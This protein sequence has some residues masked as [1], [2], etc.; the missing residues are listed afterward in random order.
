MMYRITTVCLGNICRS[1]MAEAVI[2]ARVKDAGL[3]AAVLVDSAGTDGWHIGEDADPRALQTLRAAGYD[4][5]HSGR[6]I[7]TEWFLEPGR[8]DLL[9]TMDSSNYVT[10]ASLAP[11]EFARE[12]VRML[13]SFDPALADVAVG[14]PRLD[15]PD[16]WYGAHDGFIDVLAMIEAAADGLIADLPELMRS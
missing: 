16:P 2:R 13:R 4:L 5:A 7:T 14:D 10:V 15:V 8:P 9:L 6:Q 11:D 1:P 12:R 3:A